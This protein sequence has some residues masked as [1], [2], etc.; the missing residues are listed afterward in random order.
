MHIDYYKLKVSQQIK[1]GVALPP[2]GA[3][4]LKQ[5]LNYIKHITFV[6]F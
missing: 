2:E 3:E 5:Q 6:S 4:S 1:V